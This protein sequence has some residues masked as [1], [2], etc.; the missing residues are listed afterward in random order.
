MLEAQASLVLRDPTAFQ[1]EMGEMVSK[2]TLDFQVLAGRPYP[3]LRDSDLF[4][5]DPCVQGSGLGPRSAG[6]WDRTGVSQGLRL[7]QHWRVTPQS[8]H[9]VTG[10]SA[11]LAIQVQS[12]ESNPIVSDR[13]HTS[14]S[15]SLCRPHGPP[16]RNA[17]SPWA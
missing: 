6:W 3:Q 1:A 14:M 15:P 7:E 9:E 13:Y 10:E 12:H 16:W 11:Q 17:R 4:S 5:G 2:E 8:A